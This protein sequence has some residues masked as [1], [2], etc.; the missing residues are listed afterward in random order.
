MMLPFASIILTGLISYRDR[1][2][3]K[4]V[5]EELGLTEKSVLVQSE[6]EHFVFDKG[7]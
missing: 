4:Q 6:P 1:A 5:A 7:K 3:K 2:M